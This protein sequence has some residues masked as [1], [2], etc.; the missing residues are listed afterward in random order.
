MERRLTSADR[1]VVK[2]LYAHPGGLDPYDLHLKYRLSPVQIISAFDWLKMEG[3]LSS[4]ENI[5]RL[6][7]YGRK[8]VLKYRHQLFVAVDR[9]WRQPIGLEARTRKYHPKKRGLDL[10]YFSRIDR[11]G[12][13]L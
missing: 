8:W 9:G 5:Y 2:E 10:G 11:K 6:T 12:P 1:E 3:V 4:E 7:A 13:R